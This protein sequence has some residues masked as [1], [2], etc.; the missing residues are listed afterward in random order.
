MSPLQIFTLWRE[1]PETTNSLKTAVNKQ[2]FASVA[3]V[4]PY[5]DKPFAF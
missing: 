5:Y 1:D 2:D 4:D 3:S